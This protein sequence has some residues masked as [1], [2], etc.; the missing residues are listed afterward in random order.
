[1]IVI[2]AS[3]ISG[4]SHFGDRRRSAIWPGSLISPVCEKQGFRR[5]DFETKSDRRQGEQGTAVMGSNLAVILRSGERPESALCSR[6]LTTRRMGE[7]APK[8]SSA[9]LKPKG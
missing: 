2:P 6:W 8:L 9:F 4:L 3:R 5:I 1:M 7:D